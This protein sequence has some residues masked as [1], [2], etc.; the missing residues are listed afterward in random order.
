M[1]ARRLPALEC[2]ADPYWLPRP[3]V[4]DRVTCGPGAGG[5]PDSSE[6]FLL[7]LCATGGGGGGA[8]AERFRVRL[9]RIVPDRPTAGTAPLWLCDADMEGGSRIRTGR[10]GSSSRSAS[11]RVRLERFS[12][13]ERTGSYSGRC[14]HVLRAWM[15]GHSRDG[16]GNP[17]DH[18]VGSGLSSGK[19][20]VALLKGLAVR[21]RDIDPDIGTSCAGYGRRSFR[22]EGPSSCCRRDENV[23]EVVHNGCLR[24]GTACCTS[25]AEHRMIVRV[26]D[27]SREQHSQKK[28]NVA[29][30]MEPSRECGSSFSS[31]SPSIYRESLHVEGEASL[32]YYEL[33]QTY[34]GLP[35]IVRI[36]GHAPYNTRG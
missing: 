5:G 18:C 12:E 11:R 9:V 8:S 1:F 28:S 33:L 35:N 32:L 25:R 34:W 20:A 3:T 14:V 6:I 19:V 2:V 26:A 17:L 7:R 31:Y 15:P 21:V 13:M 27:S 4:A 16:P 30:D 29:T 36:S 23:L 22:E 10:G 24:C